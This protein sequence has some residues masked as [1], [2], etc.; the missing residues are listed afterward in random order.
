M[1]PHGTDTRYCTGC[2][3]DEC[4][5]AHTAGA[6]RRRRAK[7]YGRH[8]PRSIP[9]ISARRR[10]EALAT[11]GWSRSVL[12][13]RLG[14]TPD[15]LG[16]LFR[17]GPGISPANHARIAALFD[18]LWDREPPMRTWQQRSS[19]VRTRNLAARSGWL[20]PLALDDDAIDVPIL[21]M[22]YANQSLD[23][24]DEIAVEQ[25]IGGRKVHLT[26]AE[27]SVAVSRLTDMGLPAREIA[28]RLH[29][30]ER[31]VERRR[32]AA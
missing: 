5:A 24:I 26:S 31:T 15:R 21:Q 4:R 20:P 1:Q 25:A 8:V 30:S 13:Q 28:A 11:L 32:S 22:R 3:C 9:N 18:E 17:D 12:S 10:I 29:V 6:R 16:K 27:R 23:F 14:W 7:A 2:R 19:A